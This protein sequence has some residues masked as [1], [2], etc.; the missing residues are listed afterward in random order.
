[1]VLLTGGIIFLQANYL[2]AKSESVKQTVS[3]VVVSPHTYT[4]TELVTLAGTDYDKKNVPLGDKRYVTDKAKKGYVYLC[5]VPNANEGGAMKDGPWISGNTWNP[6][7]KV[8][9]SGSVTWKNASFKESVTNAIRLLTGNGLPISH[10][11]GTFPVATT[12]KAYTYDRN[13]NTIKVQSISKSLPVEPTYM[14]VPNCM[15]MEV[16]IMKTGVPLFNS[17]DATL[18]D[19]PAHE[20]QDNCGG[21]PQVSGQY[22]YHSSSDV[23]GYALDGFPITGD[24]VTKTTYLT[25]DDLDECHGLTSTIILDGKKK[26]MYHYVMTKDFPYS[27]SCFRGKPTSL[28]VMSSAMGTGMN[29]GPN[30]NTNQGTGTGV[31][32]AG[33]NNTLPP[34]GMMQ[35][36]KE[37]TTVCVNKTKQ[38][39]CSFNT[40]NGT[41]N[42]VCDT[43]PGM[44]TMACVP[45]M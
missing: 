17:F 34:G 25:T 13:P 9:I 42:G 38:A 31:G 33:P 21:H 3:T 45:K 19:A 24:M 44:T 15:G 20:V 37:A 4:A 2:G 12:D 10:A 8:A 43:P 29:G 26:T 40:P 11:T 22:H 6:K 32:M 36:P 41:M 5:S 18:R 28:Q 23:I 35:P 7:N 14:S 39:N 27:V 1:L 16:G 30:N